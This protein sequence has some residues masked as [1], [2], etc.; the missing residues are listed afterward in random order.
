MCD[1]CRLDALSNE[2]DRELYEVFNLIFQIHEMWRL[3]RFRSHPEWTPLAI[4]C[5]FSKLQHHCLYLLAKQTKLLSED[6]GVFSIYKVKL[7]A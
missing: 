2:S 5:F 6:A 4:G 3:E 7:Q 1:S